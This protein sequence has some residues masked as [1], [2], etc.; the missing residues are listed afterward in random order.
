M[1]LMLVKAQHS[2]WLCITEWSRSTTSRN[3]GR[4]SALHGYFAEF[5]RA[6]KLGIKN[7]L[8]LNDGT[9][10]CPCKYLA[11][12]TQLILSDLK[13]KNPRHGGAVMLWKHFFH[14]IWIILWSLAGMIKLQIG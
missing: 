1:L 3:V 11:A 2:G 4:S 5:Y 9:K 14:Y 13:N 8:S 6:F 12:L 7:L 10:K